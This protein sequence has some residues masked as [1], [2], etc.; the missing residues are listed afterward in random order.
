MA[1][2][3]YGN[4]HN[5]KINTASDE[6]AELMDGFL[7]PEKLMQVSGE[8]ELDQVT[9][10]VLKLDTRLT[11]VASVGKT[12]P[13]LEKFKLNNSYIPSIRDLGSGYQNLTVLWMARCSLTELDGIASL[14]SLKELYL[15][16]NEL[17][18]ISSIGMLELLQVLDLEGNLIQDIEQVEELTLCAALVEL[19]LEGNPVTG[20]SL[21]E[22]SESDENDDDMSEEGG[23]GEVG[24]GEISNRRRRER[25]RMDFRMVVWGI[26][27]KLRIL[28]DEEL[29]GVHST[30]RGGVP[31]ASSSQKVQP[32]RPMTSVGNHFN[33]KYGILD[34]NEDFGSSELTFGTGDTMAGNPVL[35]LRSRRQRRSSESAST[36]QNVMIAKLFTELR[37]P[38]PGPPPS[39]HTKNTEI[40]SLT[41]RF[42]FTSDG[43]VK[44]APVPPT[45]QIQGS[46]TVLGRGGRR[47]HVVKSGSSSC[48]AVLPSTVSVPVAPPTRPPPQT[49]FRRRE[50]ART[51]KPLDGVQQSE[52]PIAI[53]NK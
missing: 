7:S 14:E 45:P 51:L 29:A 8:K 27:P 49:M 6:L 53:A 48:P 12:L 19:T 43:S 46:T 13:N 26:L 33:A 35:F 21:E 28:D 40:A 34:E 32:K 22:A 25:V 1:N 42:G 4:S 18:D 24:E 39:H 16:N 47:V 10:I 3:L 37:N 15:A 50:Y 23:L 20:C 44:L 52:Q 31:L 9:S 17:C 41:A 38:N 36:E 11:S 2:L 5:P 30:T